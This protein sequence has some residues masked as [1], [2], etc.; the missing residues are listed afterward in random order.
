MEL[1]NRWRHLRILLHDSKAAMTIVDDTLSTQKIWAHHRSA[2][3]A[4]DIDALM[5]D[6]VEDSL[7]ATFDKTYR[8][9]HEIRMFF[10]MFFKMTSPDFWGVFKT[11]T[12]VIEGPIAYLVWEAKPFVSM[13]TDTF[14][15]KNDKISAQTITMFNNP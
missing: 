6:Y 2:F 13:G 3:I 7:V 9:L 12:R 8:G 5:E 1:S 11:Q 10:E 15:I 14:V 4:K